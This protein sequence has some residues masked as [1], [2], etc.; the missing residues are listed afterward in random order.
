MKLRNLLCLTIVSCC[1]LPL[2][3]FAQA[4]EDTHHGTTYYVDCSSDLQESNGTSQSS[5]WKSLRQV[6]EHMFFPG[7]VVRLRRGTSCQGVLWPKGSGSDAAPIRLTAYGTGRRPRI[8]ADS[9]SEWALKLYNQEYWHVDSL[10]ILGST[11]FGVFI[12]GNKGI[13]HHI[14]LANLEVHDVGGAPMKSKD[15]G[16]IMI[17]PGSVDQHFDDVLIDG[18]VAYDTR[19]WA[20]IMVGGGNLGL[21]PEETWSTHVIIRN[22]IVHDVQGDGIVLFRVRNGRI[23]NSV[24]WN[25]GMQPTESIGTPN[26]IWTWMC[27]DCVVE[28]NEAF[29][30]DS[31]GVDGGAYDIDWGNTNNKVVN[32]FGHDTQ[33]YCVAVFAA[34]YVTRNSEVRNNTCLNNARSPRM[35]Q[36]QGALF[37][38]TWNGGKLDELAIENNTIYWNPP[39]TAPAIVNDAEF[40]GGK[41]DVKHN[42]IYSTSPWMISSNELLNYEANQYSLYSVVPNVDVRWKYGAQSLY[43]L[44]SFKTKS[45]QEKNGILRRFE[46]TRLDLGRELSAEKQQLDPAYKELLAAMREHSKDSAAAPTGKWT[47][48]AALS[49]S[50][51]DNGLL[52]EESRRQLVVLASVAA[53]YH[54]SGLATVIA[55]QGIAGSDAKE[56]YANIISDFAVPAGEFVLAESRSSIPEGAPLV[57]LTSPS[58]DI[59]NVWHGFGGAVELGMELRRQIGEPAL[60]HI[61]DSE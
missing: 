59:V 34:G 39:N 43:G 55:L 50:A 12:S 17:S 31:P 42:R 54:G 20:G 49:G 29:L 44:D 32:N 13:L 60:A 56:A 48:Y 37:V 35:A 24:A 3:G 51:D 38:H 22:S 45:G 7:D 16:L 28:Q 19:Q 8:I 41:G 1:L 52:N 40:N 18:V 14:H 27:H 26:A 33:G 57:L 23:A 46:S 58:G 6:N 15:A 4:G 25:T 10:E 2:I 11:T 30:T 5:P 9:N 53:Q 47:V 36:F 21:P 61:G